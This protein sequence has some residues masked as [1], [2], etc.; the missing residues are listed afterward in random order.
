MS[1]ILFLGPSA[2]RQEIEKRLEASVL[3][4][5]RQGDIHR[6]A[7]S[8]ARF[9]G[10]VDGYFE[11]VPAVWHK[12]ILWALT[13]GI[14]VFGAASMGALRAA[15]L[16]AFGMRGVGKIFEAYRSGV[17]EDDD[18]VAVLHGP[19]EAGYVALNEAM[20]NVRATLEQA[21]K[22]GVLK[23]ETR[24]ALEDLAKG[25][26]YQERSWE[27][28]MARAEAEKVGDVSLEVLRGWLID[29]KVDQKRLDSLEMAE[30]MQVFIEK[31]PEPMVASFVF[32]HTSM[33]DE[34]AH[35]AWTTGL[36]KQ[37]PSEDGLSYERVLDELR[38]Q[39]GAFPA[40]RRRSLGRLF[41]LR[42][43]ERRGL[44][45]ERQAL[46][47]RSNRFRLERGLLSRHA[48]DQ[49]LIDNDLDGP[50][51]ERMIADEVRIAEL[52]SL[53][54]RSLGEEMLAELRQRGEYSLLAARA[55]D[56]QRKLAEI[57][58][59]Q[60]GLGD[61]DISPAELLAWFFGQQLGED[62]P[63]NPDTLIAEWGLEDIE[64]L[65][66]LLVL[67]YI[68]SRNDGDSSEGQDES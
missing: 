6:A 16:H 12:E 28:L 31:D 63:E 15:E 37:A 22:D 62:L 17:L 24:G 34:A 64:G 36:S 55:R 19:P 4:P 42:E 49:W 58:M 41:A 61:I 54:G 33:W 10:L 56:K 38:L 50:A 44:M 35:A 5:A 7:R 59:E 39:G 57:G 13:Q 45:A 47:E 20:V 43:V 26:F 3:P 25:M 18:E 68:Y 66:R 1:C 67:E 40:A 32:E 30:A 65:Y 53:V 14:H 21:Q 8:G 46:Q 9:I 48:L 60:A 29:R 27:S 23:A 52:E 51:W 11:G 2:P